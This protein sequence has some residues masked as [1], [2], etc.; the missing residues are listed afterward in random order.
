MKHASFSVFVSVW[1]Q[2]Q[3][4][5]TPRVH[6]QIAEWLEEAWVSGDRHLLLMAFRACGKSTLVAL[7]V[8]WVLYRDPNMRILILSAESDLASKMVGNI[9]RI[10]ERHPLTQGLKPRVPTQWSG[11][12]L[13]IERTRD[14]RDP[15]VL[16]RGVTSNITG[17]R[18]DL[19]I[20]DDVEVPNTCDSAD[21]RE[22]LR[23]RLNETPFILVPNGTMLYVGTPHSYFSLYADKPREEIGEERVF[24]E[25]YTRLKIPVLTDEG[26]SVWPERF[27]LDEIADQRLKAGPN[28]F[29]SQMMLEPINILDGHLDP[30]LLQFYHD[31][32]VYSEA[33]TRPVLHI[34]T[35][36]M[37]SASAWWDPAFGGKGGDNSVVAIVFS[38][39]EGNKYIHSVSYL[40]I[41]EHSEEDEAT[42]QC[43][44]VVGLMQE[45]YV[46]SVALEINGLGK[47]L[48]SILRRELA[49]SHVNCAV[50]EMSSRRAKELR[51]LE[52]FDAPMAAR[53]LSIHRTVSKTPFLTEMQEWQPKKTNTYDDGLDA[54]AGALSLEPVRMKRVYSGGGMGWGTGGQTHKAKTVLE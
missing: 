20:C 7:F 8:A 39:A 38:D 36:Q 4:Y 18:A 3:G 5:K 43:R 2:I 48:P 24:L 22:N 49:K 26:E 13:T 21:K 17:S 40:K 19:I 37:V 25:G 41:D 46:P 50:L 28:K 23:L 15:S 32:L 30:T 31:D 47:F 6:F 51:I 1:N 9:R 42:Q 52:A 54:V 16:A 10:L 35:T 14:S 44:A 27:S 11:D 33:Q 45:F 29:Q 34:G 12:R 53:S